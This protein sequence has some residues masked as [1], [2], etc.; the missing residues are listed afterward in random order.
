MDEVL[1]QRVVLFIEGKPA[2]EKVLLKEMDKYLKKSQ[3]PKEIIWVDKFEKTKTGKII[4]KDY[5]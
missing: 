5:T 1:G 3:V 4:R 2:N